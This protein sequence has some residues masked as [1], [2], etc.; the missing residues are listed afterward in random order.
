MSV[1]HLNPSMDRCQTTLA[2]VFVQLLSEAKVQ[3][4]RRE[5]SFDVVL[6]ESKDRRLGNDGRKRAILS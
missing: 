5:W 3:A 4:L 6:G 2:L 1:A